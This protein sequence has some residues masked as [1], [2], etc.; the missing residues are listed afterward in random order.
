MMCVIPKSW[1]VNKKPSLHLWLQLFQQYI[2]ELTLKH[3]DVHLWGSWLLFVSASLLLSLCAALLACSQVWNPC[4]NVDH[5]DVVV[6]CCNPSPGRGWGKMAVNLKPNPGYLSNSGL[7]GAT[8]WNLSSNNMDQ[9]ST[10][11]PSKKRGGASHSLDPLCVWESR[12][13][14]RL[15]DDIVRQ[16]GS[17]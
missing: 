16:D 2:S 6:Q 14:S 5:A 15:D 17:R 7:A 12:A 4:W 1:A 3:K 8:Q 9:I 11:L 10:Y 13:L